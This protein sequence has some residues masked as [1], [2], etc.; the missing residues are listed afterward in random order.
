M[1]VGVEVG[2]GAVRGTKV[3]GM[4]PDPGLVTIVSNQ[5]HYAY[6][7]ESNSESNVAATKSSNHTGSPKQAN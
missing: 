6:D 5:G 7:C 3:R 1:G 4:A 2:R